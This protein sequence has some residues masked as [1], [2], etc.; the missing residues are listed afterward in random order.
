MGYDDAEGLE[1]GYSRYRIVFQLDMGGVSEPMGGDEV[2]FQTWEF[3]DRFG[4]DELC[5]FVFIYAGFFSG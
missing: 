2:F 5:R 1:G 3:K 4:R